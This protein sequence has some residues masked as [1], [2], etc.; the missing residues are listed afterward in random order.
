[1]DEAGMKVDRT[2]E[3]YRLIKF[4][5]F[6]LVTSRSHVPNEKAPLWN[7]IWFLSTGKVIE[8]AVEEEDLKNWTRVK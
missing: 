6:L 5:D 1:M 4:N 2:G 3:L 7:C 8:T